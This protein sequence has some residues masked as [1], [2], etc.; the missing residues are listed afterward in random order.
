MLRITAT[1]GLDFLRTNRATL[2]QQY[3]PQL[4]EMLISGM[5][6]RVAR[7]EDDAQTEERDARRLEPAAIQGRVEL[8]RKMIGYQRDILMRERDRGTIDE[9]VMRDVLR[10]LDAEELALDTSLLH[11]A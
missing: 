7:Q 3:D 2:A 4:V 9:E 6:V 11:R 8:R 5:Q 1:E 10:G